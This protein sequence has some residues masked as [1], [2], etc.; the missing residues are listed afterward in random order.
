[1]TAMKWFSLDKRRAFTLIE[2]LVVIA[3]IAILASMLLPALARAQAKGKGIKCINNLKQIGIAL[4]IWTDEHEDRYPWAEQRKS[5]RPLYPATPTN[6]MT[7]SEVLS[8]EVGGAMRV[9]QCPNDNIN[10]FIV[11]ESSY[12]WAA[13]YNG[14]AVDKKGRWDR[15]VLLYDYESWHLVGNTNGAKNILWGDGRATPNRKGL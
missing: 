11:E 6:L 3:I 1:M 13:Q 10:A 14:E 7:I 4:R 15:D 5:L 12:E 9:F 2:L 8:N